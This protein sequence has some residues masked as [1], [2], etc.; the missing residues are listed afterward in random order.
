MTVA[1]GLCMT[2]E[3]MGKV[4]AQ[5]P[6]VRQGTAEA[7]WA[8]HLVANSPTNTTVTEIAWKLNGARVEFVAKVS[9]DAPR[10]VRV[11]FFPENCTKQ[12]AQLREAVLSSNQPIECQ[13]EGIRAGEEREV[14]GSFARRIDGKFAP[15]VW[16]DVVTRNQPFNPAVPA[17]DSVY[18]Q[19]M[20]NK[21]QDVKTRQAAEGFSD[22]VATIGKL[23]STAGTLT[24]NEQLTQ[25][26]ALTEA[27]TQTLPASTNAAGGS[28][29]G[30]NATA[31]KSSAPLAKAVE[32]G[33]GTFRALGNLVRG[34]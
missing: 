15:V 1:L 19:M 13:R 25:A 34:K 28:Q 32:S 26:G 14:S 16:G 33:V 21:I 31:P 3:P 7:L 30:S 5:E 23:S 9:F 27:L 6:A 10:Y 20:R 11:P 29:S 22:F 2:A 12:L 17:E 18:A 24:G 8:A 4:Q